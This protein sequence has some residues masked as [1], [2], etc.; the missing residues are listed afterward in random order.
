MT[1][2]MGDS[3]TYT[4][5]LEQRR[6]H[7]RNSHAGH[8]GDAPCGI[9]REVAEAPASRQHERRDTNHPARDASDVCQAWKHTGVNFITSCYIGGNGRMPKVYQRILSQNHG[10]HSLAEVPVEVARL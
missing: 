9:K 8:A 2:R 3:D 6:E 10:D 4:R 7:R 1:H 5:C